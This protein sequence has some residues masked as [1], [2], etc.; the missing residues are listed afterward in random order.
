VLLAA[1]RVEF[2]NVTVRSVHPIINLLVQ[3]GQV[4]S[5]STQF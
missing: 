4:L 5:R 2:G 3:H 1:L